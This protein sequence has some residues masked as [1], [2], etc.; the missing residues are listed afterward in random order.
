MSDKEIKV[1]DM[2]KVVGSKTSKPRTNLMGKIGIVTGCDLPI[3][4]RATRIFVSLLDEP[5]RIYN[6]HPVYLEM[7]K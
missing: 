4:S 2:V 1:G 5:T 6:S 7:I 3:N